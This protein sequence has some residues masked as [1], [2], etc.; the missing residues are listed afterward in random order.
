MKKLPFWLLAVAVTLASAVFQRMTGPTHPQ[1]VA[2]VVE[3]RAVHAALPRSAESTADAA[4][5]LPVAAPAEAYLEYRHYEADEPW[6]RTAFVRKGMELVGYLP[7]QPAAGKL[8]YRV[9]VVSGGRATSITGD[10]PVVIRF[11]DPVPLPL[12]VVHILVMFGGMLTSTAA[13][14]AALDRKRN[15]RHFALWALA[16]IF[17]GGFLFGPLVQKYAFGTFWSGFPLG[18][19]LTD[20]KTL[21]AFLFWLAAVIA[22]R[23]GRP[24]RSAV[25]TASAAT[26]IV[27]LIPHSVLGSELKYSGMK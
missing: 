24:A 23:K 21:F 10:K 11:K 15:P 8:A 17:L 19:D 4:V 5:P 18:T 14:L 12:L 9:Y 20:S 6:T 1:R 16:L 3:S 22:G 2:A 25:L 13:G 7:R 26:L 27:F